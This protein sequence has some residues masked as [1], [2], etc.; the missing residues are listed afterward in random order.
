[1]VVAAIPRH[2]VL[3][4]QVCQS[5]DIAIFIVSSA[6]SSGM[7]P[8]EEEILSSWGAMPDIAGTVDVGV[9]KHGSY[10]HPR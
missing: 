5:P 7:L 3:M 8:S 10:Y 2:I 9:S 1:M 6:F 4:R